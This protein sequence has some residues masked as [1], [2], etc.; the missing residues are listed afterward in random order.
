MLDLEALLRQGRF[1]PHIASRR[2]WDVIVRD[3]YGEA[4]PIFQL[5]K[6]P[7]YQI[8]AA[9]LSAVIDKPTAAVK[10]IPDWTIAIS[11]VIYS[12]RYSGTIGPKI[13]D[14]TCNPDILPE[15]VEIVMETAFG[16]IH[17]ARYRGISFDN[18]DIQLNLAYAVAELAYVMEQDGVSHCDM[19]PENIFLYFDHDGSSFYRLGDFGLARPTEEIVEVMHGP[20]HI[21]GTVG[22]MSPEFVTEGS[23]HPVPDIFSYGMFLSWLVVGS[24]PEELNFDHSQE[25]RVRYI[26]LMRTGEYRRLI[27]ARLPLNSHPLVLEVLN[28]CIDSSSARPT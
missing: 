25:S 18:P 9:A 20:P 19:K 23:S 4:F 17:A 10:Y 24:L 2:S 11:E 22:Y 21:Y 27:Q 28:E 14:V 5:G 8:N 7:V 16:S 6:N 3:R 12:L 1:P 15:G 13:Y 26:N